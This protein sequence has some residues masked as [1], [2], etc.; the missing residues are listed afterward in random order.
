MRLIVACLAISF[1]TALHAAERLTLATWNL[2]WMMTPQTFDA[3][4][5]G[6]IGSGRRAGGSERAI[7]CNLVPKARW[8]EGDL[9]RIRNFAATLPADVIALQEIDGRQV[10]TS[11]FPD[12]EFCFTKRR[13]VQNVGFAIRRGIP[14]R[15]NR[16]FRALGGP[17]NDVRWGADMTID[18]GTPREVRI[19]AVHLKASCN[20]DP[21]SDGRP[22]CRILQRQVP[23]L[24]DWIDRRARTGDAFAVIGDFNRRFDRERKEPRDAQ[25]A[26]VA[27]WPEIDD[28]DPEG[29]DLVNPGLEH[30]AVRC[31]NGHGARMPIDHLVFGRR[32][33]ERLVAGSY[34]VWDYPDG[35]RWPDHC[36][37][38]IELER[39]DRHGV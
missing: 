32:L 37:I 26:I 8:N 1:A 20:R 19:L 25:G 16:D 10:A 34:R 35:R 31:G 3:L 9:R 15:C 22:D 5:S 24:E 4:A 12:R 18:P 7:P 28:G 6:C 38:S 13:H 33:A 17:A 30:G 11:I 23:V 21:L 29:A 2:E 39:E 27:M 14:F 36:V